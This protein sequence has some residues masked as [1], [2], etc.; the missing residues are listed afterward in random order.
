[1][2]EEAFAAA[3]KA[4]GVGGLAGV[5]GAHPIGGGDPTDCLYLELCDLQAGLSLVRETLLQQGAPRGTLV[6]YYLR[7]ADGGQWVE[8]PL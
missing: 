1:V 5:G 3:V 4:S 8:Y 6:Q 7:S 2:L